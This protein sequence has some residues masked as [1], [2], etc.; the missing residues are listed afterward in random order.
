MFL[1]TETQFILRGT[2]FCSLATSAGALQR[3]F[4]QVQL[5]M[6]QQCVDV[7]ILKPPWEVEMIFVVKPYKS[8]KGEASSR[9]RLLNAINN[10]IGPMN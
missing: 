1:G 3:V 7:F 9:F 10:P 6:V 2:P 8:H 4:P 5:T